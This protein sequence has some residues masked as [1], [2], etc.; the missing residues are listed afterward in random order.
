MDDVSSDSE[1][2]ELQVAGAVVHFEIRG[3]GPV[4][5]LAGC[6]M[7]A[8]AFA[9]LADRLATNRTVITTDPRGINR[10]TVDDRDQDVSPEM[11]A[12]DLARILVHVDAGPAAVFGSSGGAVSALALALAHPDL[13]HTVI[14]HEPPLDELLDERDRLR[15]ETEDIVA[16]YLGGDIAGAWAKFLA[17]ANITLTEEEMAAGWAGEPDPQAVADEWFF[18]AHTL[19]PTTWWQPDIESLRAL[20]TRIVLGI[21]DTSTGQSCDRTTSALASELGLTPVGFPGGHVGFVESP[22]D[23]ADRLNDVLDDEGAQ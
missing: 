20:P 15:A 2:T 21:G 4:V 5:L 13:V 7:D 1:L 6:P 14:A 16:T 11:L 23:F 18:F 22:D 19:R 3:S 8:A 17:Q 12:D 9:P 10:S